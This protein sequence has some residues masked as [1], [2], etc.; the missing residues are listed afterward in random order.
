VHAAELAVQ[1][2]NDLYQAGS[3]L[4]IYQTRLPQEFSD[5]Q[6]I[7]LPQEAL[8]AGGGGGGG[9][10]GRGAAVQP[11]IRQ[12]VIDLSEEQNTNDV[13]LFLRSMMPWNVVDTSTRPDRTDDGGDGG[14]DGRNNADEAER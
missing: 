10:A 1:S 4:E 2:R 11:P 9:G 14:G 5:E 12:N 6:R 7:E 8:N 13:L 3:P